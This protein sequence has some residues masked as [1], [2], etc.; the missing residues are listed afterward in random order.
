MKPETGDPNV[1]VTREDVAAA[2]RG[3]GIEPGDTMLFHSALSSMGRVVGGPDAVIDGMLDAVGPEGTVA[4]PTLCNWEA[5]EQ[6]LVFE[7]WDP[8]TSPSYVGKL[9]ETLRLRPEA[10][11]SDHATHSVAAIGARAEELTAGHGASGL[12][13]SPFS[14]TAFAH[15]SPWQRLVDWN[16]AY[17]FIGVTFWV[18]TMVHYVEARL[19]ENALARA[20]ERRE[21]M[22]AELASWMKPGPFSGIRIEDREVIEEM[23]R[24]EGI[25]RHGPIGSA[26]L[27]CARA[28]PMAERWIAIV[29]ADP[30]R[31]LQDDF[32]EV[33]ARYC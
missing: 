6:H 5:D 30:E 21:E 18:N 10:Y 13:H 27:R 26:T 8:A 20:G 31:W 2:A 16:A 15:A 33:C 29:E 12:R 11:R 23:L 14:G 32:L 9:T 22:V 24:A 1:Q 19:A 4:V 28:K 17:C 7:R 3:V 25:V